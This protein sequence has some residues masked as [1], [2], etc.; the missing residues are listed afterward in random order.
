[1]AKS[2]SRFVG[3]KASNIG[4]EKWYGDDAPEEM[5]GDI[6]LSSDPWA[7]M[8]SKLNRLG[9]LKRNTK[10]CPECRGKMEYIALGEYRC[11]KCNYL[12][13]DNYGKIREYID[14]HGPSTPIQIEEATGV[15]R[16]V[17][18]SYLKNGKLEIVN[19][20]EGYL[21]C[22]LCGADIRYGRICQKCARTDGAKAKGYYIGDAGEEPYHERNAGEMRFLKKRKENRE[23]AK[24]GRR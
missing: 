12:F 15:P 3:V 13:L 11:S 1:M 20:P 24:K 14:E 9:T 8:E 5:K 22:E 18:D 16:E 6:N 19:G 23:N 4:N 17:V 2:G 7:K 10:I 21:R